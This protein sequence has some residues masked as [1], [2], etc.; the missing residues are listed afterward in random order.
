MTINGFFTLAFNN[1][2]LLAMWGALLLHWLLPIPPELHPIQ[3]WKKL[4]LLIATR[5]NKASDSIKQRQLSGF[6]AWLLLYCSAFIFLFAAYQLVWYPS[7]FNMTLLWLAIEWQQPHQLGK[8]IT[9]GLADNRIAYCRQ[10]LSTQ[11]NRDTNTLTQIGIGKACAETLLLGYGRQVVAVLF[12]YTLAG[13][14]GAILYRLTLTLAR[15]WSPS[16]IQY[17]NFGLSAVRLL[18]IADIIPLR[19]FA[20]LLATG[21]NTRHNFTALWRQGEQ[22]PLPGPGWLLTAVGS[23]LTLSLG[24]PV[25]YQKQRFERPKVG[26]PIAPAALHLAQLQQLLL[27][28]LWL[29]GI[30][31]SLWIIIA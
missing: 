13:G 5:V 16:R 2:T 24:G 15:C 31:C 21:K 29:W 25:I 19:L 11:L 6:L 28:R 12:W 3:I 26:G 9:Q 23:R 7:L 4:G 1:D 27:R 17:H 30:F 14:I 8:R 10:L 22:W 20:L 18:A